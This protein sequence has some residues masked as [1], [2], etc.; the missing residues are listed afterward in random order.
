MSD[1]DGKDPNIES[2]GDGQALLKPV[3]RSPAAASSG[4]ATCNSDVNEIQA[5][6]RG[7]AAVMIGRPVLALALLALLA[8]G[9][10]ADA[11][12][13]ARAS[14]DIG[15]HTRQASFFGHSFP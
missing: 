10:T 12:L 5:T 1:E 2:S 14:K 8:G 6:G 4:C 15:K 7:S 13:V 3:Q 9:L 11:R